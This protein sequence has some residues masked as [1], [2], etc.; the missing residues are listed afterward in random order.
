MKCVEHFIYGFVKACVLFD[1]WHCQTPELPPLC[2]I[3]SVEPKYGCMTWDCDGPT[4]T[5]DPSPTPGP[6]PS[7]APGPS[8]LPPNPS[9]NQDM[10][11][12]GV[13]AG[14]V[15]GAMVVLGILAV[16]FWKYLNPR[17]QHLRNG[18]AVYQGLGAVPWW[19]RWLTPNIVGRGRNDDAESDP[20]SDDSWLRR[21]DD[22][23]NVRRNSNNAAATPAQ[24]AAFERE[25]EVSPD[26]NQG[27]RRILSMA[28]IQWLARRVFA[29]PGAHPQNQAGGGGQGQGQGQDAQNGGGGGGQ[30]QGQ[31]QDAQNGGGGGGQGQGQ[32]HDAQNGGGGG[33]QGQGQGHDAQNGGGGGGQ[34]QGQGQDGQNGG[35]GGGQGQGLDAQNGGGGGG[36]QGQ[37]QDRNGCGDGSGNRGFDGKGG[38]CGGGEDSG[39]EESSS[40]E[41]L[42][43]TPA[44]NI[45]FSNPLYRT[46]PRR[47]KREKKSTK[48]KNF[49][50]YKK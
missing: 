18:L 49:H 46:Q 8:P 14:S 15:A 31:G 27:R 9:P 44:Q 34:G 50:Y 32:G 37:R 12:I 25:T 11:Q 20:D 19:A 16:L 23:N 5:P 24:P 33:G 36:G 22:G 1:I 41:D 38:A 13:I 21:S 17:I 35:G 10:H 42:F 45:G 6:D 28:Q 3:L 2:P 47:S 26:G 43:S 7:P 4:P 48:D 30:G 39:E 40:E 29:R